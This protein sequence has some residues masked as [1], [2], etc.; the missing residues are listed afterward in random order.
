LDLNAIRPLFADYVE[1]S[2]RWIAQSRGEKY[3]W[4]LT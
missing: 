3:A 1:H 4:P 2:Q